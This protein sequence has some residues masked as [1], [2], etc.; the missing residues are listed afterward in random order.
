MHNEW[1]KNGSKMQIEGAGLN[2]SNPMKT[3]DMAEIT[4]SRLIRMWVSS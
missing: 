4:N 1:L 2:F 3:C